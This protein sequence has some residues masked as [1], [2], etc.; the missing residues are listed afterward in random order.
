MWQVL[1]QLKVITLLERSIKADEL[2]HAYVF[3]GPPHVGKLTLATNL[4]QAVN[5]T[6]DDVPCQ[7]CSSC[8]RIAAG[9]HADV[10]TLDLISPEAKGLGIDQIRDV[11]MASSL[12]PY[13]G[14]RKVFI[15]DNAELLS[16][17]A[18][19]CLLKTL[20]EPPPKVHLILLTT[21]VSRLL[22]TV[23]S[24]CQQIELRPVSNDTARD[25]L[26]KHYG[27]TREKA[28]LLSRL[29]GGCLGWAIL[30]CSDDT[31]LQEREQ[32]IA[33]FVDLSRAAVCQ[34]LAYAAELA[35]QF[36][37]G[38]DRV[39]EIISLWLQWWRDLLLIKGEN[40]QRITNIDYEA[41]LRDE[42]QRLTMTQIHAFVRHLQA[43]GRQ[44]EQN[45]NPRLAFEVL[46]L[47]MP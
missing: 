11:Q 20:E 42:A 41:V 45:V 16:H 31:I 30:A 2:S 9:K 46:L 10:Q 12:P 1:G 15:L 3:A 39:T 23:L 27:A 4:A 34:R 32:R 19:N 7:Q 6:S 26:V 17:E 38:R 33:T 21:S 8:R 24:R 36:T 5:C 28:D 18:A 29:C 47:K 37:K 35:A 40:E 22:P 25:I 13:E 14:K 43:V 44:L